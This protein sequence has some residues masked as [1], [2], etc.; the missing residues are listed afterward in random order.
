MGIGIVAAATLLLAS[1]QMNVL[2]AVVVATFLASVVLL[3]LTTEEQEKKYRPLLG[4]SLRTLR[5]MHTTLCRGHFGKRPSAQWKKSQK[6]FLPWPVPSPFLPLPPPPLE[7][8][9]QAQNSLCMV[10]PLF[11]TRTRTL[12]ALHLHNGAMRKGN[13]PPTE[14]CSMSLSS[15]TSCCCSLFLFPSSVPAW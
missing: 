8:L 2:Q 6:V 12:C 7:L 1:A 15:S 3:P 13:L 11:R 14:A 5:N 4:P 9:L 10:G